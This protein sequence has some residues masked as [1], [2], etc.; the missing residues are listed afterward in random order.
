[1]WFLGS[2]LKSN[3]LRITLLWL[4][5]ALACPAF[6][7]VI[8]EIH[9]DP[10]PKTEPVEFIELYNAGAA[11]ANMAGWRFTSGV[12]FTFPAGTTLD[13][14]EFLVIA[15]DPVA[16]NTKFGI[17]SLG[18]WTG[19][20]KNDGE[21]IRLVNAGNL[22]EDEVNY[23][24]GFP[25]PTG[26]LDSGKSI[27]LIDPSLEN[28]LGGHWRTGGDTGGSST[29]IGIESD[30]M[31]FKGTAEPSVGTGQWRQIGFPEAG[32]LTGQGTIGYGEGF[33]KTVLTDMRNLYSTVY[34]R[35][36]F[37]VTN[38]A[39]ISGLV[40]KARYDDGFNAWI[41]GTRV[42]WDNVSAENLAFGAT[43]Q[44][45]EEDISYR[46]MILPAPQGYLVPGD[47]V[48]AVQLLNASKNG[49]SDAFWDAELEIATG[50]SGVSPGQVN[51]SFSIEVPPAIRQVNHS[52]KQPTGADDVIIT[53]KVTDPDGVQSVTLEYQTVLP[54]SYIRLSDV[55]Y[56]NPGNWTSV[57]MVDNG[58]GNDLVGLD[59]TFTV[60]IP[61][62]VQVHRRLIRYRITITDLLGHS[63]RVPY[64]DDPQPNFAY[65]VYDGNPGWSGQHQPPGGSV[66][67]FSPALLDS[68]ATYH[69]ITQKDDHEESQHIPDTNAGT[70]G[71][72]DY[73]WEGTLIYDGEVYDH[74]RYRARG[75]VW[76]YSMGKNM[77]KFRFQNGH[78]FE[79]RDDY[80]KK[81]PEPWRRLNFSA[82]IQQG[83]FL[84]RGEQG[85]FEGV[86][87]RLFN[88]AGIE[89]PNTSCVHFRIIESASETGVDQYSGDF[90]GLYL[91]IEQPD[92]RFLKTHNLDE[93]NIYKMENNTGE[94]RIGG[95]LK[96]QAGAALP[97]D[98]SD[99]A[100]FKSTYESGTQSDQWWRDN[101][102]LE[103]YYA[104]R[105]IVDGIHHF[106]IAGGKNYYYFHNAVSGKWEVHP[107]DLD[108]TWANNMYGSGNEPF[109][110]RV[111]SK[112][113]FS[114]GHQNSAREILDL[115]F[116]SDQ[117][118]RL[119]EEQMSH[120]YQ[121]GQPSLVDADRFM[122]DYNP[123]LSS[124]FVNSSKAGHGRFYESA[125]APGGFPGMAQKMKN[126]VVERGNWIKTNTLT[127]T[128]P[129]KP[130]ISYEGASGFPVTGL[131]F[132]SSSFAG[133][134]MSA[135]MIEWRIGEVYDPVNSPGSYLEG[136]RY[137][138]E[139]E[140]V[141][142]EPPVSWGGGATSVVIPVSAL[143]PG[144][145][146][147]ARVRHLATNGRWSSW[148]NALQFSAASADVADYQAGL[149]VSELMYHPKDATI[150]E[151]GLG[152]ANSDFEYIELY[153]AG[154]VALDLTDVQFTDGIDFVFAGSAITSLAPGAWVLV[155][156]N[157]AAFEARYGSGLPVA[158]EFPNATFSN[159][160]E[161][162]EI[163]IG[164]G[165]Q[166]LSF[167]FNDQV[168]WPTG[169]DDGVNGF[170]LVL[171]APDSVPNHD[172][173]A[174]WTAGSIA[175]GN[176]GGPDLGGFALWAAGFGLAANAMEDVDGD[177][178]SLLLEYVFAGGTPLVLNTTTLPELRSEQLDAGAGLKDYAVFE[179]AI[180]VGVS[181][182]TIAAE[183]SFDLANW[184]SPGELV[185]LEQIENGDGTLTVRYRST[186]P[187]VEGGTRFFARGR[188]DLVAP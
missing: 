63:A 124:S 167:T 62:S 46:E 45:A 58:A 134:G 169:A 71:G 55:A 159:D 22:V 163:S 186:D 115:L 185:F 122:W 25:W 61:A 146:Y 166:I 52:P 110:S 17:T 131:S 141:W 12:A 104:Y 90:Q 50:T 7:V 83:N 94:G 8:N 180:R 23:G 157:Q 129:T 182:V 65:F 150:T 103:R 112:S 156:R 11:A 79:A 38:P 105:T 54:G 132:R 135:D 1:M 5:A 143:V 160:G 107:W 10:E 80:G 34:L 140:S 19:S 187:L 137:R 164:A 93:S 84:H 144:R 69:L 87:F 39:T 32:W 36:T 67:T 76:R 68:V 92:G 100:S 179:Y 148:S 120:V 73:L 27:E 138:Y 125:V 151:I 70:Y 57:S 178:V 142:E 114:L 133:S 37:N 88:L 121:P 20:L 30:W 102:D 170:P 126:Y 188:V 174:N 165:S 4:G 16:I 175:G 24:V 78:G 35:K 183:T 48:L 42:E 59:E 184:S 168:P 74:I 97:S 119:I 81:Y 99:L 51:G 77:W 96:Y 123:I 21:L 130:T 47:N 171:V 101:L 108:L 3:P 176:P 106:D 162:V 41:N 128:P 86:G 98:S 147:R 85:L 31:Y 72:S 136:T 153:N 161:R 149:V 117:A 118:Y 6:P 56:D 18:P 113:A 139:I 60:T 66:T 9:Y 173:A 91:V 13:P 33:L 26:S 127:L 43:A 172:L 29:L 181:D 155:V 64:R 109:K 152:F 44:S 40:L 154:A 15:A 14:G 2:E 75:G 116:N 89:G 177:G 95:E 49:S 82:L 53:A 111:L 28:D 158:G 145:T